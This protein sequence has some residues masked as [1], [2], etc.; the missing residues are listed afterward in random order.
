MACG[1]LFPHEWV[2]TMNRTQLL[3]FQKALTAVPK[4]PCTQCRIDFS[5]HWCW[6]SD[7]WIVVRFDTKVPYQLKP[8]KVLPI[9]NKALGSEPPST[10]IELQYIF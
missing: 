6:E 3:L 10:I 7:R 4:A 8:K 2:A 1:V 5:D 9:V